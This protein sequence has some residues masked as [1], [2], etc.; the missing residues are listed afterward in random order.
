[1]HVLHP[2]V[3]TEGAQAGVEVGDVGVSEVARQASDEPLR[4]HA[5]DP[6]RALLAAARADHLIAPVELGH[7]ARD[8]I[9]RICHV[10]VGPHHDAPPSGRGAGA[11]GRPAATVDG[12]ADEA[13]AVDHLQVVFGP[14]VRS[15]VDD[16]DLER[17]RRGVE[18][19][20]DALDLVTQMAPL[21]VDGEHDGHVEVISQGHGHTIAAGDPY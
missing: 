2:H 15:V 21:V 14:V 3:A 19:L 12:V 5:E 10:D 13:D 17:V 20:L 18:R 7:E 8:Q 6:L 11:A 4:R 9:V 16:D 1:M